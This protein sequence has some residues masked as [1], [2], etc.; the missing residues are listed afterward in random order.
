MYLKRKDSVDLQVKKS[1]YT[2]LIIIIETKL[3][4]TL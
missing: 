1:L 2:N 4:G 3:L